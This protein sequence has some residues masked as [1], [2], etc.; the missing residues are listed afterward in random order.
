MTKRFFILV[1]LAPLFL[2][3]QYSI[4]GNIDQGENFSWVLLYKIKD[5]KQIYMDNADVK[6]NEFEF[7]ISENENSG[8]YRI[9]YQIENQLYI[10]FIYNKENIDFVFNPNY[11][12]ESLKFN[13]SSENVLY[14]KYFKQISEKQ[15][16]L[17]SL[18]VAYF[19][20]EDVKLDQEI[21]RSYL[22][23]LNEYNTLQLD[24]ENQSKEKLA[25][26]IIK[27][28]KQFNAKN[29]IKIPT[30][31][32]NEVKKHFFDAINFNDP[33]LINSTFINDK[34]FDYIFY[35]NQSNDILALN[36]MQKKSID[37]GLSKLENSLF[38]MK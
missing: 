22:I 11:P 10:E 36:E 34:I 32:L 21:S 13:S 6:N 37:I 9:F 26:H 3:A 1:F 7:S 19:N 24:Y 27:A 38:R 33:I 30:D 2:H 23:K 12:V 31:Y 20:S 5:G 18:Q 16:N 4:K 17:D 8:I 29:P 15:Q 25:N 28:S 14:Q 35:L